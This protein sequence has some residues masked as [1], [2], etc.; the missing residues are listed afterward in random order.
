MPRKTFTYTSTRTR[1]WVVGENTSGILGWF[2]DVY[3]VSINSSGTNFNGASFTSK[4]TKPLQISLVCPWIEA[5]TIEFT[6]SG[7][8]TRTID[9][10]NGDCDNKATV[11][12]AGVS[13][14]ITLR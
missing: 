6:P 1:E 8:L 12:I 10:G 14:P 3:K 2:D 7:K 9:Y 13:F 4:T 5:G 11:T